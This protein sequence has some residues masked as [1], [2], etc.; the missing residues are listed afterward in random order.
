MYAIILRSNYSD[1]M[2]LK[3][4]FTALVSY[5]GLSENKVN[6]MWSDLETAYNQ[7]FRKYHNLTHLEELFSHFDTFSD[8]LTYKDDVLW[9]IFY[10]DVVYDIWKKDNE[11]KSA[12]YVEILLKEL[13]ISN[14]QIARVFNLILSTKHHESNTTDEA[15][16]ID[17]DLA[18]LGQPEAIYSN[19][20]KHIRKE[21]A[22]VPGLLY[23]KG[24]KKV[25]DHFLNKRQIYQTE[26][27]ISNYEQQARLNLQNELTTL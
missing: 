3:E 9:S 4:R 23:R 13:E 18:I 7:K 16:M 2:K 8:E 11:L 25:L 27:F 20:T 24:R 22:K 17:F 21:Y 26:Q 6:S 5:Y 15:F 10:H 12:Q 14:E 1:S 19:Y